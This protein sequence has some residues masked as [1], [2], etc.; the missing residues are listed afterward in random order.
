MQVSIRNIPLTIMSGLRHTR[1]LSVTL[2]K[3][4]V[5]TDEPSLADHFLNKILSLFSIDNVA[6][7]Q[8][9]KDTDN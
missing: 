1:S 5:T 9:N 2:K 6:L 8:Q 3:K 7:K 4:K